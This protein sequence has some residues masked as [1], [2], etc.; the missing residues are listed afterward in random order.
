MM[1]MLVKAGGLYNIILVVFHVLFWRIF[2]WDRELNKLSFLNRAIMQVLNI[3]L[4]MVFVIFAF[5]SFGHTN[6]LLTSNLGQSLLSLM[7]LF[8]LA[9]SIQQI[10]FFQMHHWISWAFLLFFF[11]GFMIYAIPAINS[12]LRTA[13]AL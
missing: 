6:E 11:T 4:I 12:M 1:E 9:R 13:P 7:A 10:V 8:W 5:L 3:S 2:D